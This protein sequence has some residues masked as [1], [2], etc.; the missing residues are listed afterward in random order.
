MKAEHLPVLC[1]DC[2]HYY[3]Y[4][5]WQCRMAPVERGKSWYLDG[6]VRV[7]KDCREMRDIDG[8]CGPEGRLFKRS[9]LWQRFLQATAE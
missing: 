3:P 1:K 7:L 8:E 4:W 9:T 6:S 5:G 2:A